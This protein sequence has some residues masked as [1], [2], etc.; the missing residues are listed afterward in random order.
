MKTMTQPTGFVRRAF[1]VVKLA[2]LEIIQ[3]L[4][5]DQ[6]SELVEG[7]GITVDGDVTLEDSLI[8]GG[9]NLYGNS[10]KVVTLTDDTTLTAA[11]SGKIFLIGTDAKTITLPATVAGLDFTFVNIGSAG[12]NTITIDPDDDDKIAGLVIKPEGGNA[13]ATTDNG[14]VSVI[15]GADGKYLQNTK[16]TA[17][18]GDRVRIVGDGSAGWYITEGLGIWAH[19]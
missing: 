15:D 18:T 17:Q 1:D 3:G 14:L 9:N 11:D 6:I 8:L 19:E 16:A 4:W 7:G 5:V 12:N 10:K 13:D 2:I